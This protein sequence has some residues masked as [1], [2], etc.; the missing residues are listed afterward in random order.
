[1]NSS[2]HGMQSMGSCVFNLKKTILLWSISIVSVVSSCAKQDRGSTHRAYTRLTI[3]NRVGL[4]YNR[5]RAIEQ[6]EHLNGRYLNLEHWAPIFQIK[7]FFPCYRWFYSSPLRPCW[8]SQRISMTHYQG[9]GSG[10]KGY[11][12]ISD[13][14]NMTNLYSTECH[15]SHTCWSVLHGNQGNIDNGS[16]DENLPLPARIMLMNELVSMNHW[17]R[18]VRSGGKKTFRIWDAISHKVSSEEQRN[19]LVSVTIYFVEVPDYNK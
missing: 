15:T 12:K 16:P 3:T 19:V 1:M 8:L 17:L 11:S 18:W 5:A 9:R 7:C 2:Q 10:T 4:S 14:F 13:I 6:L